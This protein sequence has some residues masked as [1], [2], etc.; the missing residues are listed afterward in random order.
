[1]NSIEQLLQIPTCLTEENKTLQ[2]YYQRHEAEV[3]NH[4]AQAVARLR[5]QPELSQLMFLC[6]LH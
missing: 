2:L 1:M 5:A 6:L 3:S 4:A